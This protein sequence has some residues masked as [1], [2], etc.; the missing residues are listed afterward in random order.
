MSVVSTNLN[1]YNDGV[2][3]GS[4]DPPLKTAELNS[5]DKRQK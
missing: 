5:L 1:V 3:P 4:W 2:T